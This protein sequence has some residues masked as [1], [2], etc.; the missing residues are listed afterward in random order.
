MYPALCIGGR[1]EINQA[2]ITDR[3]GRPEMITPVQDETEGIS[4]IYGTAVILDG[5]AAPHKAEIA[6]KLGA[7]ATGLPPYKG[8]EKFIKEELY[9]RYSTDTLEGSVLIVIESN[10]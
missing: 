9:A 2:V 7:A 6:E 1:V 5:S 8:A 4:Y 10:G 3:Q